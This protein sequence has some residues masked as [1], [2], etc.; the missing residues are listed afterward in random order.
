MVEGQTSDHKLCIR[1]GNKPTAIHK[2]ELT[3]TTFLSNGREIYKTQRWVSDLSNDK[4]LWAVELDII[5]QSEIEDLISKNRI[6]YFT[7]RLINGGQTA[8]LLVIPF[9]FVLF[10]GMY[11]LVYIINYI[12][13]KI[14]ESYTK[15]GNSLIFF[16]IFLVAVIVA[17]F[18][19]EIVFGSLF[20]IF[21]GK[22]LI[23]FFT[24]FWLIQW[25]NKK[26]I[27]LDFGKKELFKFL[28]I[29]AFCLIT[30]F[31]GGN[32][33]NY[34]FFNLM[35]FKGGLIYEFGENANVLGWFKF[36][37][38]FALA[39]FMSNPT[40]YI[41]KLRGIEKILKRQKADDTIAS[42]SLASIQSRINPLFLYNALNS[43]A[44]LARTEPQKTELM[45]HELAKF[46]GQCS[47]RKMEPLVTLREELEILK[48]Y[49]KIEKIRFGDRLQVT[50]SVHPQVMDV[51]LPPF[52][53]QPLV[54]NAIKYG[55]NIEADHIH[56]NINVAQKEGITQIRIYDDGLPFSDK[57]EA[58]YGINSIR[59]KLKWLVPDKH[60][61]TFV[62]HPAKY[63]EI[64]IKNGSI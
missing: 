50:F 58:G 18:F 10:I 3:T 63:V 6:Y 48:S 27:H 51:H 46:Y 15:L 32:I 12:K 37:I 53:L 64:A 16:C 34:L 1:Y 35:D 44:S 61:M 9:E 41:F 49:L 55:Y 25:F 28:M 5:T 4:Q 40:S 59:K 7:R 45:A 57:L 13:N 52:I 43:I 24:L 62:N 8:E 30:E 19:T 56:I 60:T 47:D 33:Y 2:K 22:N 36:W 11:L 38:Y 26:F 29:A 20:N 31:L 42:S 23:S 39:N 21:F 14:K 17:W 54:E